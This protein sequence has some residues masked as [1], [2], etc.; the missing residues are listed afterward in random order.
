MQAE[1]DDGHSLAAQFAIG[2]NSE[3]VAFDSFGAA[4]Q[5]SRFVIFSATKA[6]VAMA[7][8]PHLADGSLDLM[9]PVAA[10]L[11]EFGGNGKE[12][13]PETLLCAAIADCFVLTFRGIARA[14]KLTFADVACDV[15]GKLDRV[16]GQLR[17][18]GFTLRARLAVP[19][20][21][22]EARARALLEKAER[23]CLISRSLA[24]PTTL[25]AEVV[26]A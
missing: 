12:W 3:I 15:A 16:D 6:I 13:S 5:D 7:L 2:L 19:P 22:D 9:A 4:R 14:S 24:A 1:I 8:L 26:F 25:A 21:T 10:Y 17:F 20:D 23:G 11:P 18:T